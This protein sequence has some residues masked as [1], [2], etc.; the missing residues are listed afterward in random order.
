MRYIRV[1]IDCLK[2][3]CGKCRFVR[4]ITDNITGGHTCFCNLFKKPLDSGPG[5]IGWKRCQSCLKR[6]TEKRSA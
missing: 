6:D 1:D 3:A 2:K 5:D 4:L